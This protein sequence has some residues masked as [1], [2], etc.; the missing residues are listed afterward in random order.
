MS[1]VQLDVN[2]YTLIIKWTCNGKEVQLAKTILL[3]CI[4]K[5]IQI[6][7][8]NTWRFAGQ[9]LAWVQAKVTVEK[10][11]I[12]YIV[13]SVYMYIRTRRLSLLCQHSLQ[14][15]R[16]FKESQIMLVWSGNVHG[17]K[18]YSS[19]N[20]CWNSHVNFKAINLNW[21]TVYRLFTEPLGLTYYVCEVIVHD[22]LP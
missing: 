5:Y 16:Y 14:C 7:T 17:N 1:F 20:S 21:W 12:Q 10:W 11:F 15:K 22:V 6:H 9:Q 13:Y 19:P 4:C 8:R 18:Q 2:R 3:C